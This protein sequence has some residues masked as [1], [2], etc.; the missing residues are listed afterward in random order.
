MAQAGIR[1]LAEVVGRRHLLEARDDLTGKAALI[2]VSRLTSAP[3]GRAQKR[4]LARQSQ[5]HAPPP[6]V[7]EAEAVTR[8]IAGET[9]ELV[10]RLTN[11]D[12]CVGVGTAGEVARRLCDAG[13]PG[14]KRVLPHEDA[15][16]HFYAGPS[17][18]RM[19][20]FIQVLV[21]DACFSRARGRT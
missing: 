3:P 14:G 5:L 7:R 16:R 8:A 4:S 2:D 20:L 11:A 19:E 15:A 21:L 6:R 12:R 18:S 1:R 13:L 9:V 17:L 10:Q